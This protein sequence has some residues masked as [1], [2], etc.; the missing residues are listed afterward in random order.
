MTK[1]VLIMSAR[2]KKGVYFL[3]VGWWNLENR[4]KNPSAWQDVPDISFGVRKVFFFTWLL[5][6]IY[7]PLFLKI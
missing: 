4:N 7:V 2:I 3:S 1:P 6:S 5:Q